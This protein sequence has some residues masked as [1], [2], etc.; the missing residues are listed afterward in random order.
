MNRSL[1]S[2][3]AVAL[4]WPLAASAVDPP[5]DLAAK[6]PAPPGAPGY[7]NDSVLMPD[8]SLASFF[9]LGL[10]QGITFFSIRSTDDGATWSAPDRVAM[11]PPPELWGGPTPL[12]DQ[13]GELHFIVPKR[14]GEG[15]KPAEDVFID[16]YHMRSSHGRTQWTEPQRIFT[17]YVGSFQ[18][19]IQMK[20]GRLIAPFGAW[21]AGVPAAPPHGANAA[22]CVYSDDGGETW[23]QSS[24]KLLVPGPPDTNGNIYGAVEP[25]VI[26]LRDGRLWML[27][28]TE[29]GFLYESFSSDGADWTPAVPS[30]FHSSH[31]PASLLRL[32]DG[33]LVIF[34]NNCQVCPR[35]GKDG[36][37]AGRDALHGAISADEGKTWAGFREVYRDSTRNG[38]PPK[39]GDRGTA[40]PTATETTD[41]KILLVSGQGKE[42]RRRFLIDPEWLLET[43]QADDFTTLDA[44]HV[45]K[46][47]GKPFRYWRDRVQG[48]ELIAHP[49]KPAARVLHLRRPDDNDPDG[50]TWNFPAAR[51]GSLTLR[52]R[53]GKGFAGGQLSLAD[54]MFD[55]CDDNGEKLA[56]F[57]LPLRGEEPLTT[58]AWHTLTLRWN[59]DRCTVL[60]DDR[61]SSILEARQ[62][63][64]DGVSY[65]RL[66]STAPVPD[67]AGFMVESVSAKAE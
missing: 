40:Y 23:Q 12:L 50:A 8:G 13:E 35:V 41:G 43:S 5:C 38:S 67:A 62:P 10:K 60:V 21:Q 53:T 34:W 14:R 25:V 36:V 26:E 58:D 48:P 31:S 49:G 7:T 4:A 2:I 30:H 63:A 65:L 20:S 32:H 52:I 9:R 55:P 11:P 6:N 54:R 19:F 45:F 28:R 1:P 44:W 16:L 39:D 22:T 51:H 59:G 17:G 57:A 3:A 42:R 37:Y 29:A 18:G 24:A 64:P 56:T 27:I 33:R 46:G 15:R 61:Q 66:R 47:V